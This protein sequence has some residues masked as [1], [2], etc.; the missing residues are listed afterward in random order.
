MC[1]ED[2]LE[3]ISLSRPFAVKIGLLKKENTIGR[4]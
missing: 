1:A 2:V 4:L 3:K